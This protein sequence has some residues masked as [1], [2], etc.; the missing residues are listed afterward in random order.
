[1]GLTPQHS[2]RIASGAALGF[3]FASCLATTAVAES[4]TVMRGSEISTAYERDG[5]FREERR[6][7]APK[8]PAKPSS[9]P[10]DS[11]ATNQTSRVVVVLVP[12][13]VPVWIGRPALWLPHVRDRRGLYGHWPP[14]GERGR[15]RAWH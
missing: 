2:L 12:I 10:P 11:P 6:A 14:S 8:P 5:D 7:V 3:F 4:V 1:M 9:G 15:A 13:E